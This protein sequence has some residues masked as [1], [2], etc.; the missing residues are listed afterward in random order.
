MV[1]EL[2]KYSKVIQK[3]QVFRAL[4]AMID[5]EELV[6]KTSEPESLLFELLQVDMTHRPVAPEIS[7]AIF[8]H[9]LPKDLLQVDSKGHTVFHVLAKLVSYEDLTYAFEQVASRLSPEEL[10]IMVNTLDQ[11]GYTPLLRL[12]D[13][14]ARDWLKPWTPKIAL[15]LMRGMT[16]ENVNLTRLFDRSTLLHRATDFHSGQVSLYEVIA[17]L[18]ALGADPSIRNASGDT[19]LQI[20]LS[21]ERRKEDYVD[22]I[23]WLK[24]E[25]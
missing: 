4:L 5:P 17:K 25:H 1:R 6:K 8:N 14:P 10:S 11:E 13:L 24:N 9:L 7:R 19:A 20:A 2:L 16:V 15:I 12:M 21:K 22:V 23:P 3:Q 18:L